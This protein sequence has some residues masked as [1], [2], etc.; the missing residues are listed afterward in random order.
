MIVNVVLNDH[1]TGDL[2]YKARLPWPIWK[3]LEI[4]PVGDGDLNLKVL[5]VQIGPGPRGQFVVICDCETLSDYVRDQEEEE[6]RATHSVPVPKQTPLSSTVPVVLFRSGE[7]DA[8]GG[9]HT[10]A[11]LAELDKRGFQGM[12]FTGSEG[13][14]VVIEHGYRDLPDGEGEIWAEVEIRGETES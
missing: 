14:G 11:S 2:L 7:P 3:G 13:R 9:V 1:E 6:E 5:S 12:A 8:G 10:A 4:D